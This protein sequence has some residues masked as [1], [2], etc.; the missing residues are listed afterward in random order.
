MERC[1][2]HDRHPRTHH[3][4]ACESRLDRSRRAE[5]DDL[6]SILEHRLQFFRCGFHLKSKRDWFAKFPIVDFRAQPARGM[7][8]WG[9]AL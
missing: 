4:I 1:Y 5:A 2:R 6:R 8:W 7:I 3:G 9:L